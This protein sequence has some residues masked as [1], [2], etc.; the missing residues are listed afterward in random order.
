MLIRFARGLV[1]LHVIFN[2]LSQILLQGIS[3]LVDIPFV[4]H[5]LFFLHLDLRL[6][7]QVE[8]EGTDQEYEADESALGNRHN[9]LLVQFFSPPKPIV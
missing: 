1:A 8:N 9:S 6:K 5:L 7:L 4:P 2:F 3:H